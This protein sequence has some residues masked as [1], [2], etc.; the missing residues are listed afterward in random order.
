MKVSIVGELIEH[1]NGIIDLYRWVFDC[2]CC[3][4][5]DEVVQVHREELIRLA[6][7]SGTYKYVK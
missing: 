2:D 4:T 1:S 3:S 5:I 6:K 7:K